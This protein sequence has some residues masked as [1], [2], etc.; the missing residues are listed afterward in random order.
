MLFLGLFLTITVTI[1]VSLFTPISVINTKPSERAVNFVDTLIEEKQWLMR[2]PQ[3]YHYTSKMGSQISYVMGELASY[4][5]ETK[6][7]SGYCPVHEFGYIEAGFPFKGFAGEVYKKDNKVVSN[8][9]SLS[10]TENA[11]PRLKIIPLKPILLPFLLNC[12]IWSLFS[13]LLYM[14]FNKAFQRNKQKQASP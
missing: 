7:K 2:P 4:N 8:S 1:A 14:I 3:G 11:L 5:N 12:F 13:Y 9:W 10:F 6:R